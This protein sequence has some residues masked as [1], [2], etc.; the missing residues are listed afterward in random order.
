VD[1][2][3]GRQPLLSEQVLEQ[4]PREGGLRLVQ[5]VTVVRIGHSP[6][7]AKGLEQCV[8]R[9]NRGE[10]RPRHWCD[11]IETG[12]V[13]QRLVVPIGKPEPAVCSFSLDFEEVARRLVL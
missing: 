13:E 4:G 9:T 7:A 2:R 8:D 10:D 6:A 3:H 11:V 12:D 1:F 5:V